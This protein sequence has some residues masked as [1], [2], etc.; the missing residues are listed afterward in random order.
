MQ[1]AK[2][3]KY[4]ITLAVIVIVVAVVIQVAIMPFFDA[5]SRYKKQCDCEAK[6]P[7]A[8]GRAAPGIPVVAAGF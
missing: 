8:N 3:E 2:R 5:R 4:L 1:L 6:K 7:G